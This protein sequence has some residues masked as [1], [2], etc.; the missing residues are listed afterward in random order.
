MS[1]YPRVSVPTTYTLRT[2]PAMA[3][4][5][6]WPIDCGHD[7]R[8]NVVIKRVRATFL[9]GTAA[10]WRPCIWSA[11]PTTSPSLLHKEYDVG[12]NISTAS[13]PVLH[14]SG[15]VDIQTQF[16]LEVQAERSAK[17]WF[18]PN[19]DAG[20]DNIFEVVVDLEWDAG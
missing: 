4:T 18:Q 16:Q 11:D 7:P 19:P 5:G 15:S 2:T 14:D 8:R 9:S 3:A 12:G 1:A 6:V 17:L 13:P 20:A 10:N